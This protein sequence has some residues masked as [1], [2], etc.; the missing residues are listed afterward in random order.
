MFSYPRLF[1]H[2]AIGVLFYIFLLL[3]LLGLFIFSVGSMLYNPSGIALKLLIVTLVF[4]YHFLSALR[5]KN[6]IPKD[7]YQLK[8]EDAPLLFSML[9]EL[10]KYMRCPKIDI[11]YIVPGDSASATEIPRFGGLLGH[12]REI[13]IG[14]ALLLTVQKQEFKF[15]LA[16]ELGHISNRHG[17]ST[18][19]LYRLHTNWSTLHNSLANSSHRFTARIIG[20]FLNWY[21]SKLGDLSMPIRRQHELDA[22]ALAGEICGRE[23]SASTLYTVIIKQMLT[24]KSFF[25]EPV[26]SGSEKSKDI[27]YQPFMTIAQQ[28]SQFIQSVD[29]SQASKFALAQETDPFDTHP[30][31]AQRIAAFGVKTPIFIRDFS[32]N[33]ATSLLTTNITQQLIEAHDKNWQTYFK[34][35]WETLY[36]AAD[37]IRTLH[38]KPVLSFEELKKLFWAYTSKN[39]D[40][41]LLTIAQK[42]LSQDPLDTSANFHIGR[43][44]LILEHN[45]KGFDYLNTAMTLDAT[46]LQPALNIAYSTTSDENHIQHCEA[47]K[48][49]AVT[50]LANVDAANREREF[51][52]PNDIYIP[53]N[54][55]RTIQDIFTKSL[56]SFPALSQ[57]VL[58]R[59]QVTHF[60]G[61]HIYVLGVQGTKKLNIKHLEHI[62][63]SFLGAMCIVFRENS[64]YTRKIMNTIRSIDGAIELMPTSS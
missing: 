18:A 16:H 62:A 58:V 25:E 22:D 3:T 30:C 37:V 8:H 17:R 31:L 53:A 50:L 59:K 46:Y 12:R 54:L 20:K 1:T 40:E 21:L 48:S 10:R 34:A 15:I 11:I 26:N 51:A 64:R 49:H 32:E 9:E 39:N 60:P 63:E 33:A 57:A 13:H 61:Q 52:K 41:Q 5:I 29:I 4:N 23:F 19:W 24:T 14:L 27:N 35:D 38:N 7:Y 55:D 45:P 47:L 44:M 2:I 6:D 43:I 28:F 56:Q 36:I 42:I